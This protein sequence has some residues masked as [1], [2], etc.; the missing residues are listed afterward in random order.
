MRK[1]TVCKQEMMEWVLVEI[2]LKTDL[3]FN[4]TMERIVEMAGD[5]L[6]SD[7]EFYKMLVNEIDTAYGEDAA[8]NF[9]VDN[10]Y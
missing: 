6:I 2:E 9:V 1:V 7:G 3:V 10:P 5:G 8:Y 4:P